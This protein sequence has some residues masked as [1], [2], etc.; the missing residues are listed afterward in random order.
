MNINIENLII[1]V[2]ITGAMGWLFKVLILEREYELKSNVDSLKNDFNKVI[3][4]QKAEHRK[5][6]EEQKSFL[7][8]NLEKVKHSLNVKVS[9][10]DRKFEM[11]MESYKVLMTLVTGVVLLDNIDDES[12]NGIIQHYKKN[13]IPLNAKIFYLAPFID[14]K[15]SYLCSCLKMH[16]RQ[17]LELIESILKSNDMSLKNENYRKFIENN[18]ATAKFVTALTNAI[19]DRI[20]EIT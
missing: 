14:S 10:S 11:E 13:I 8:E 2:V 15:I 16:L 20:E 9:V 18:K 12:V 7:N 17:K 1:S 5:N 4:E 6:L 19:R 3:E